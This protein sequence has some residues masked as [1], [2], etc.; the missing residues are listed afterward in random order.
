MYDDVYSDAHLLKH[1]L[2]AQKLTRPGKAKIVDEIFSIA[3]R[4]SEA[5]CIGLTP[6]DVGLYYELMQ[7]RW[8]RA[9][10]LLIDKAPQAI[11][12]IE[13]TLGVSRAV[14]Y[15]SPLENLSGI[16]QRADFICCIFA[17][18]LLSD[19]PLAL[20]Q[21]R[22]TLK[23]GGSLFIITMTPHQEKSHPMGRFFGPAPGG[24]RFL[25]PD[26][27][28]HL[29][30]NAGLQPRLQREITFHQTLAPEDVPVAFSK[31]ANSFLY[32]QPPERV[33]AFHAYL[34][35]SARD[36]VIPIDYN[37][38]LLLATKSTQ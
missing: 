7:K 35:A 6:C 31:H 24:S 19:L 15:V 20:S 4:S 10:F 12:H 18:H 37:W 1:Y 8:P 33:E 27:L 28:A 13:R 2:A 32:L 38:T 36:A 21:L 25:E 3:D 30:A 26:V 16:D 34:Y 29:I 23:P 5:L 14:A 22:G 9:H 17:T 11:A